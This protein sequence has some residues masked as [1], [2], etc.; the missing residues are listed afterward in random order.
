MSDDLFDFGREKN[1]SETEKIQLRYNRA[2]RLKNSPE[3]VQKLH[4]GEYTKKIGL[5][6]AFFA[7][8]ASALLALAIIVMIPFIIFYK[9]NASTQN[10]DD[11]KITL[12]F[13]IETTL[14]KGQNNQQIFATVTI[15]PQ[16]TEYI[17]E[18]INCMF[19]V[20]GKHDI[21]LASAKVE[22]VYLG[23]KLILSS[24]INV[25][26]DLDKIKALKAQLEIADKFFILKKNL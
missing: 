7:T 19:F 22:T 2:E 24:P 8:P 17:G 25:Q 14:N 21:V 23:E 9:K 12:D 5:I 3:S 4:A 20:V 26:K 6:K 18:N 15:E 1:N 16:T 11:L 10:L 13:T